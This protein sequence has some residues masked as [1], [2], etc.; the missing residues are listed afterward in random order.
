MSRSK[1]VL[2][3]AIFASIPAAASQDL[4]QVQE[5]DVISADVINSLIRQVSNS[6][7]GFA[8]DDELDGA[9]QC[10]TYSTRS[11]G[12]IADGPLLYKKTGTMTFNSEAASFNYSGTGD[13]RG[14]FVGAYATTGTFSVRDGYLVT[15]YGVYGITKRSDREF[16]WE[17]NSASPPNGYT[18]CRKTDAPP[19]SVNNLAANSVANGIQLTWTDQSDNED[20]F[21]VER[22]PVTDAATWAVLQ[23]LDIDVVAFTDTSPELGETWQYRVFAFNEYGDSYTSSVVQHTLI[24][25]AN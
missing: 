10:D 24:S 12:C 8:S 25:S 6:T 20:G 13:P 9:W 18:V 15:S 11:E 4:V 19:E 3:T 22:K 5:G 23:S 21:R 14:C 1:A 17:L 2:A 16:L 7:Q